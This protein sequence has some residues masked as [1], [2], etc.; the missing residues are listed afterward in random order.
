MSGAQGRV[1]W[2]DFIALQELPALKQWKIAFPIGPNFDPRGYESL[3]ILI[4]EI[5]RVTGQS[6]RIAY[7]SADYVPRGEQPAVPGKGAALQRRPRPEHNGG[8]R[9]RRG[10]RC[11]RPDPPRHARASELPLRRAPNG[12]TCGLLDADGRHWTAAQIDSRTGAWARRSRQP[13]PR[14]ERPPAPTVV[15][16][17]C[18]LEDLEGSVHDAAG[19]ATGFGDVTSA[20]EMVGADCEVAQAGH[21]AGS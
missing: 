5:K 3:D 4:N 9:P 19:L 20:G 18:E 11:P 14:R 10:R 15:S 16:R 2:P 17:S 13:H 21:D 8:H 12:D 1:T 7:L 6:Y